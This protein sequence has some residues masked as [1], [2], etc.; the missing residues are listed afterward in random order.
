[1]NEDRYRAAVT[2]EPIPQKMVLEFL[3]HYLADP[4]ERTLFLVGTA[5]AA[6]EEDGVMASDMALA[7]FT[8]ACGVFQASM[9]A[10]KSNMATSIATVLSAGMDMG[11]A[12]ERYRLAVL[13]EQEQDAAASTST[14]A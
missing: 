12:L 8:M 6:S 11:I 2:R 10:M 14:P 1:M 3:P 4:T 13:Q 7:L 5:P 9:D